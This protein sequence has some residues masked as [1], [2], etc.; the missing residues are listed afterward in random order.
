MFNP[1][2]EFKLL[3]GLKVQLF[4]SIINK[5]ININFSQ[6]KNVGKKTKYKLVVIN[7][8][9]ERKQ[10]LFTRKTKRNFHFDIW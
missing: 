1:V 4:C 5:S 9:V 7:H 10:F 8:I 6:Q 2:S 3:I